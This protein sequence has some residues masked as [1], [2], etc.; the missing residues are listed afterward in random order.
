MEYNPTHLIKT[1]PTPFVRNLLYFIYPV[2]NSIWHW[3]IKKIRSFWHIFTGKK[4]IMIAVDKQT[5][6][7]D[8]VLNELGY[9]VETLV[10]ENDP[11]L[12]E[13]K[14]FLAGL[15]K[16]IRPG[17]ITF[18]A[19]AKGVSHNEPKKSNVITWAE[20]LYDINLSVPTAVDATLKIY[21]TAGALKKRGSGDWSWYFEG[22]FFWLKHDELFKR[23]WRDILLDRFGVE[24]YPGRQFR[25]DEGHSFFNKT[26]NRYQN[27]IMKSEYVHVLEAQKAMA[28]CLNG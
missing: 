8:I 11:S 20:A 10:Q 2:K 24:Q 7:P 23:N 19:H 12:G 22:A 25:W 28:K 21:A 16:L 3:N 18:Y 17:E 1:K 15:S 14:L 27:A 26:G 5:D 9:K 13:T 6:N 4:I